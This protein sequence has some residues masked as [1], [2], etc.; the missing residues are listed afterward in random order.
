MLYRFWQWLVGRPQHNWTRWQ[1]V[2]ETAVGFAAMISHSQRIQFRRCVT[3]GFEQREVVV[4]S[5]KCDEHVSEHYEI[6][7]EAGE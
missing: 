7:V 1:Q 3:C 2:D 6:A 5:T 4:A